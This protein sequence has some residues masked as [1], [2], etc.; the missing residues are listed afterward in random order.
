M[1]TIA[2]LLLLAAAAGLFGYT[3]LRR[4]QILLAVRRDRRLDR[5]GERIRRV[6]VY[7]FGQK[8]FLVGEQPAGIMHV[9][10]FWGFVTV[11]IRTITLFGQGF[12]PDFHVPGFSMDL[13]GGPYLLMKD[14]V[15]V[16]VIV[17]VS[18]ALYRWFISHP[19]RLFGFK[20]AEAKLAGHS[21]WEAFLILGFIM[22][23]MVT[24]LLYDGGRFVYGLGDPLTKSERAW[25][26]VSAAV[27]LAL[28]GLDVRAVRFISDASW[29]IHL[30]VILAFMN[31]LPRSKHFH[32]IT[33]IPNVFF[34]TLES[35]GT[36]K[37]ADLPEN[38]GTSQINHFTWKQ[39]LDMYSCTECGRCTASCPATASGSPLAPRQLLLDLRDYLYQH[40]DE[41]IAGKAEENIVG[42][43]LIHNDVLWGCTTCRACEE[44]CP[45]LIEYVDKI[46]DMR[47]HLVERG[48]MDP[49]LQSVLEKM[50]RY[51]NSFGQSERNRAKWTQGLPFKIK[52]ARK[53]PVDFLW[54]VG[55]FASY[56]PSLQEITR[57]VARIFHRAGLDFGILYEGERNSGNDVRRVGEEG[58]YQALVEKNLAAFAKAQFKEIVTTDPH[59]YN[60]LKHEYP[61]FG[62]TFTVRH[63]TEVILELIETGKLPA[64]KRLDA[65]VTYHDPCYL[66]RY[67]GVTDAP[68]ATLEALGLRLVEMGRNR[69][70]TFCCGAGGGRIW[71]TDTGT[72]ERPSE[73]RI[74]EALEIPGL[75]YFVVA[76]PKDVT[77]YRDAV[78]TTGNE[79]RLVV[80]DLI[81]LVEETL[82]P[83]AS[84]AEVASAAGA[85]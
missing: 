14:L 69:A 4:L 41:V 43:R 1:T 11:S 39:V 70:N 17:G 21:H 65:T 67:T 82:G 52:D 29:W 7:A 38:L 26:P 73:Q 42:E 15:E 51:G 66:S 44:A 68:R 72:A 12:N 60:T 25:S 76:C 57:G 28:S 56:D 54:F 36:L 2:L 61:E 19:V 10:I 81:E 74:R 24:D 59:S 53:E 47:R 9:L 16:G 13:L 83:E 23:L 32:I 45:V 34:G 85:R 46:V 30:S 37:K 6:L 8:K 78:K 64:A 80:K 35:P 48:E 50:G 27:G 20:P 71:M 3:I 40:Q 33:A 49:T 63:Y 18:I 77:M 79:G 31:L 22:T 62:G 84:T 5:I 55:D 75:K 58:L